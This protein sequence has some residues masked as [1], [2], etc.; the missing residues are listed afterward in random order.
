MLCDF[1]PRE[2]V[3]YESPRTVICSVC[4]REITTRFF[5]VTA[6]CGGSD[7]S[8]FLEH[9]AGTTVGLGD[10]VASAIRIATLG[11]VAPTPDCGCD[12]RKAWLN[13]LWSWRTDES[14]A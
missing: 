8:D 7:V 5:P 2:Y 14:Q 13:N 4:N 12:Q 10:V 9:V 11:M 6:P 1:G 3:T